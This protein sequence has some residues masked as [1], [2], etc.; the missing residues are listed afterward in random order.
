MKTKQCIREKVWFPGIDK[1][2]EEIVKSCIPCQA[3]YPGP[4]SREPII[5][6]QLPEEPWISVSVDFAGPFPSGDYLLVV[7]D[8]Y[9][10]FPE[11]EIVSST[12]SRAILPELDQIFSRQGIP[13]VVRTDNGPPFNGH[14]FK[15]Y[16]K[17]F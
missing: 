9:S 14:E 3:S 4:S 15:N 13:S 7:I 11:V 12:S 5:P 6:T 10:R 1:Q 17:Q 2:V 16:A 8:D